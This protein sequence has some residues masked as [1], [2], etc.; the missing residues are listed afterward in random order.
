MM[1]LVVNGMETPEV[2]GAAS[3]TGPREAQAPEG[4]A[5]HGRFRKQRGRKGHEL[6]SMFLV[7]RKDMIPI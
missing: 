3:L 1:V 5:R 7:D 4:P 6:R 2:G